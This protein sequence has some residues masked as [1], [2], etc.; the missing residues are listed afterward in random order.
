MSES[1]A[2]NTF[3][4]TVQDEVNLTI[5]R[6]IFKIIPFKVFC[7]SPRE[8]KGPQGRKTETAFAIQRGGPRHWPE[9]IQTS[10]SDLNLMGMPG[11]NKQKANTWAPSESHRCF[12]STAGI[13]GG[14]AVLHNSLASSG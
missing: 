12:S 7:A 2:S 3:T 11:E 8:R 10:E 5:P 1:S 9:K 6:T 4:A 14:K 13:Q